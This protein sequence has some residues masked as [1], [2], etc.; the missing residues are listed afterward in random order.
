MT[1]PDEGPVRCEAIKATEAAVLV[2]FSIPEP[3]LG[4]PERVEPEA[5]AFENLITVMVSHGM[6][7]DHAARALESFYEVGRG[8]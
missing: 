1:E 8:Q 4:A 2:A 7:R 5:R 3:L 6:P